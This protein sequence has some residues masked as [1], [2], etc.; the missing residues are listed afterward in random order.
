VLALAFIG[1]VAA[2]SASATKR[3]SLTNCVTLRLASL[4]LMF[5]YL[6]HIPF[7]VTTR[8]AVPIF[9]VVYLLAVFAI[10]VSVSTPLVRSR[11]K[12]IE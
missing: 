8:Y 10:V 6:V 1:A 2:W 3:L 12:V 5:V 4:F 7:F 11:L 9:P